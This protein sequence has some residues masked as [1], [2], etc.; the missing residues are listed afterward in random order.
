MNS[1]KG[2]TLIELMIVVAIVGIIAAMA[3]P[4]FRR[5]R[6]NQTM[7]DGRV[8][9]I[10]KNHQEKCIASYCSQDDLTNNQASTCDQLGYVP[11][12]AIASENDS[13]SVSATLAVGDQKEIVDALAKLDKTIASLNK[14]QSR[15]LELESK[16]IAL[17]KKLNDQ[18]F[19]KT[20]S[21]W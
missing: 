19:E 20:D 1:Q 5:Y 6:L 10:K 13:V 18:K 12:K 3:I 8:A 17:E 16:I 21:K 11:G 7:E 14:E 2:F 15:I 9:F 4:Q